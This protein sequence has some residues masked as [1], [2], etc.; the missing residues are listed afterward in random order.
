MYSA[1][2]EMRARGLGNYYRV[3]PDLQYRN[4]SVVARLAPHQRAQDYNSHNTH[5]LDVEIEGAAI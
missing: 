5:R 3:V 2:L 4:T 1:R